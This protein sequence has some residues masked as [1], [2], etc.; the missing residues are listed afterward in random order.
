MLKKTKILHASISLTVN[1]SNLSK[2]QAKKL[3]F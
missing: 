1:H 2:I 3:N